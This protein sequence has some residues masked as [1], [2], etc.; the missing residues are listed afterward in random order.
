M[1][2]AALIA[3]QGKAK[4]EPTGSPGHCR[5]GVTSGKGYGSILTAVP[6]TCRGSWT[7]PLLE[8]QSPG[9]PFPAQ[10]CL[11]PG[12]PGDVPPSPFLPRVVWFYFQGD[13]KAKKVRIS[14]DKMRSSSR[15]QQ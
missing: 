5:A 3:S 6:E 12:L 13:V 4:E 1:S 15:S 8:A 2:L 9:T 11:H 7:L 10:H 14:A